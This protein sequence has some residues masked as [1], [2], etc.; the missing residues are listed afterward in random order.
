MGRKI[1][2]RDL[3][4]RKKRGTSLV[5]IKLSE[6]NKTFTPEA[7]IL[8]GLEFAKSLMLKNYT[9]IEEAT[10]QK[11]EDSPIQ[12]SIIDPRE[13]N[14]DTT[15]LEDVRPNEVTTEFEQ[16]REVNPDLTLQ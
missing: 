14:G 2:S 13:E 8:I 12:F 16:Q 1:G 9:S 15:F 11:Q 4:P 7:T 10:P 3:K 6:L 5:A